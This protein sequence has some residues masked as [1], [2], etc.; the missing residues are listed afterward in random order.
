MSHVH[1]GLRD[2]KFPECIIIM[3]TVYSPSEA[4][5]Q[6]KTTLAHFRYP[7][8]GPHKI[9]ETDPWSSTYV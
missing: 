1:V 7:A 2:P 8:G 5:L 6:K 9:A 4:G 3:G